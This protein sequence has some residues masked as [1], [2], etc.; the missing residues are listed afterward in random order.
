[1]KLN[2]A[3][4]EKVGGDD[5]HSI[6]KHKD[7][8]EFKIMHKA[9]SKKMAADFKALPMADGGEVPQEN[10]KL[11]ESKKQPP[12]APHLDP[13]KAK[14]FVKGFNNAF[15]DGG[16]VKAAPKDD[17]PEPNKKNAEDFKKGFESPTPSL[18]QAVKNIKEGLGFADGGEVPAEK[19]SAD[20]IVA[21]ALNSQA[22]PQQAPTPVDSNKY[23]QAYQ[24]RMDFQNQF[25]PGEPLQVKEGQAIDFAERLKGSD[26]AEAAWKAKDAQVQASQQQ[27]TDAR[28][29]ALGIQTS[30]VP[31]AQ[32]L[33]GSQQP[34]QQNATPDNLNSPKPPQGP[35]DPYGTE[36]YYNSLEQGIQEQKA[37]LAGEA[38]AL[39]K[40]G[41]Q[42]AAVLKNAQA[43]QQQALNTYK[44][45]YDK[46]N[47][48]VQTLQQAIQDQHI[49]PR[50][51]VNS[52]STGSQIGT[53]IGLVLG[54]LSAGLSHQPNMALSYFNDQINKDI[55]A[56]K[57][58]LGKK[59]NLLSNNMK[60]YGN[61]RD[62][63]D[64]TRVQQSMIV[65][66][67]LQ[68]AA[69]QNASPLAQ[70]R[71]AQEV[72]KIDQSNAATLSQIAMRRTLLQGGA[73]GKIDPARIVNM[74]VPEG[75]RA[76]AN[77][78]LEEA[79]M[80]NKS[81]DN[82]L[83]SFDKLAKINTIGNRIGSPIQ[84][85]KQVDAIVGPLVAGLSKETAGRFTEK[86]SGMLAPLFPSP[87]DDDQ[88]LNIKRSQMEK[89]IG[90]KMNFP[91]L[92]TYGI[93]TGGMG[94]YGEGGQKKIQLAPP[95][96]K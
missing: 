34:A 83:G 51:Y 56:Q 30:G 2:M 63:M 82:L 5:S 29:Q 48:S 16:D 20:K 44:S 3:H 52:M 35:N 72:G 94:R 38:T 50:H 43:Q 88:T 92:N 62:A 12:G 36:A 33:P 24:Q 18:G 28:K 19:D 60:Q 81:R 68:Q 57:A 1:M 80:M 89:L 61:L 7:G 14:K 86:D 93:Q 42:Q 65:G 8:H 84:S 85:K 69:A 47:Q 9:L 67:Q 54:G 70:A 53:M 71:A 15:A 66:N 21:D 25:T 74:V 87:G 17:V 22:S 37:G 11:E 45:N 26:Q 76:A 31:S 4:F 41:E 79:Q 73:N 32:P 59:E 91:I 13:D 46:I 40:Q 23:A 90:E 27:A 49:D 77:K 64:M 75:Q 39:G 6:M 96:R 10:P 58:E 95:V 55:D 78:E